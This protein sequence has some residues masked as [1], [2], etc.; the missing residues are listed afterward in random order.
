MQ[1]LPSQGATLK[2]TAGGRRVSVSVVANLATSSA[3]VD[4]DITKIPHTAISRPTGPW[5]KALKED[6]RCQYDLA[7][8]DARRAVQRCPRYAGEARRSGRVVKNVTHQA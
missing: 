5:E 8:R 6:A 4:P 3:I 7:A 2:V 1:V